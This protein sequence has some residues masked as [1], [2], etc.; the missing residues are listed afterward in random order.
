MEGTR[1]IFGAPGGGWLRWGTIVAGPRLSEHTIVGEDDPA[2]D[3]G[4]G[5]DLVCVRTDEIRVRPL[6]LGWVP[7][8]WCA[9]E[10]RR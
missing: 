9:T 3:F 8:G 10:V 7:V 1:V 4:P 6:S 2:S 5:R